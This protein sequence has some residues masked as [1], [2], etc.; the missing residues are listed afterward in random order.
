MEHSQTWTEINLIFL[1]DNFSGLGQ[2]P[3]KL[4]NFGD[5]GQFQLKLTKFIDRLSSTDCR[6]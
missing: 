6:V 4:A 2:F 5:F 1:I 3:L